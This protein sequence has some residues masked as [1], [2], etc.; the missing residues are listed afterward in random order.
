[1]ETST[2]ETINKV[3]VAAET[4]LGV[5]RDNECNSMADAMTTI[6]VVAT[7]IL[8]NASGG[9]KPVAVIGGNILHGQIV[10]M[11]ETSEYAVAH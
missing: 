8:M 1:M 10:A 9:N 4:I 3:R 6:S 11:I 7:T 5:L 2:E